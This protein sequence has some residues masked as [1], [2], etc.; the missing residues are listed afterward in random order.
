MYLN[1][2]GS[3]DFCKMRQYKNSFLY[4]AIL[5]IFAFL[6]S[7]TNSS[8]NP[9]EKSKQPQQTESTGQIVD[10]YVN[11]LTTAQDKAKKAAGAENRRVEEENKA[12]Q[13]ME[14]K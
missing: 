2:I 4:L 9:Q 6:Y 12:V 11:T 1:G 8:S 3:P 7:C 10:K 14:G 5:I 13:E